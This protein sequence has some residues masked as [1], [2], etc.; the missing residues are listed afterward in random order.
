MRVYA[1][2]GTLN[3]DYTWEPEIFGFFSNRE[4]AENHLI[5]LSALAFNRLGIEPYRRTCGYNSQDQ[6]DGIYDESDYVV[7]MVLCERELDTIS[8]D[9]DIVNLFGLKKKER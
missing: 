1:L 9:E 8:P 3:R 4:D 6:I 7:D 2:L 5:R